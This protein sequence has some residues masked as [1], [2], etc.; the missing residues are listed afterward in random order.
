MFGSTA[1]I[2]LSGGVW[3]E[4]LLPAYLARGMS[5]R[6]GQPL[7]LYTHAY[8]ESQ[9]QGT[10]FIPRLI[11]FETIGDRRFFEVFTTVKGIGN[12]KALRAMEVPPAELARAIADRDT[13]ALVRLPEIGKRLAE[14][15][16]AELNGKVAAFLS[17][18]ERRDMDTP[19]G[20][21]A[22]RMPSS[23]PRHEAVAALVALGE[24]RA[25]AE[26]KVEVVLSRRDGP[27][28]I[29]ADEVLVLVYGSA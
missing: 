21:H 8:L 18:S 19:S 20:A 14:T 12:R 11:G 10:S 25:D 4:V 26:R 24:T 29:T 23:G 28:P 1:E 27:D 16:I 5:E 22:P 17:V 15:I 6:H 3:L 13:A 9:G 2:R 7:S